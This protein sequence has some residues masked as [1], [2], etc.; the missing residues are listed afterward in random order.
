MLKEI[1]YCQAYTLYTKLI[2]TTG[3]FVIN[4]SLASL[5][6]L[7]SADYFLRVH[8]SYLVNL[9]HVSQYNA[10]ALWLSN[11]KIPIGITYKASVQKRIKELPI[12]EN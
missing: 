5:T 4:D 3:L 12:L 11:H 2:T 10:N 1:L 7:L 8:K 9:T 6:K